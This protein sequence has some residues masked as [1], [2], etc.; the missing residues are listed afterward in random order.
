MTQQHAE[1][2]NY[3]LWD[4]SCRSCQEPDAIEIKLTEHPVWVG[5]DVVLVRVRVAVCRKCDAKTFDTAADALFI[6]ARKRLV[7]SSVAGWQ[8]VGTVYR[9]S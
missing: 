3:S 5:T 4:T 2:V 1:N 6:A 9:A 7:A 8:A